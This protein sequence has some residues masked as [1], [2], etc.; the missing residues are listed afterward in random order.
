MA[1]SVLSYSLSQP[2]DSS[3]CPRE[4]LRDAQCAVYCEGI[5]TSHDLSQFEIRNTILKQ[6]NVSSG[7]D[8]GQISSVVN[9]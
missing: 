2:G 8:P 5:G 1:E 7:V 9:F 4:V 6:R 3:F